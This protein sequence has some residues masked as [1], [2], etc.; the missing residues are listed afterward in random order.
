M[1]DS[2]KLSGVG[3][4]QSEQQ[5]SRFSSVDELLLLRTA[6]YQSETTG[7]PQSYDEWTAAAYTL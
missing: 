6:A 2:V 3:N 7:L 5:R 4:S 1:F